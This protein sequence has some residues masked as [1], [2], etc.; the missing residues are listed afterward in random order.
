MLQESLEEGAKQLSVQTA[1]NLGLTEWESF[2]FL[3]VNP[4]QSDVL[5]RATILGKLA[6]SDATV[7]N[8]KS[9]VQS[10]VGNDAKAYSITENWTQP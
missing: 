9:I 3:P 7:A 8:I 6:G 2:L 4:G 1:T 10:V 5:R